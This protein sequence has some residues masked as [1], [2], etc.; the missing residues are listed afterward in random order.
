VDDVL[1]SIGDYEVGNDGTIEF[2]TNERTQLTYVVQEKQIGENIKMNILRN[3]EKISLDV[4]LHRSSQKDHLVSMEQYETL[5][6]Y[7]IYGGLIFCPLSKN[8]LNVWGPQW[9]QSAPSELIYL[10]Q[11]NIPE[12]EDQQVVILLKALASDVND[13]Y[14]NVRSWVVDTINGKKIWNLKDFVTKVESIQNDYIILENKW[15]QQIVIDREMAENTHR[16]ILETYR[17]PFDR[18]ED[19]I[20]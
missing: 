6:S 20:K 11:N 7:Y 14:Q 8:L 10:L 17:I 1:L 16:E 5:P 4:N 19:L 13:G 2:R 3:G 9:Y 12:K 18:S 15:E